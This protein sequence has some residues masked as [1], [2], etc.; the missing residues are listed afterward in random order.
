M[1]G[2]IIYSFGKRHKVVF[3]GRT[4][5]GC[6]VQGTVPCDERG[7][8]LPVERQ[9][10]VDDPQQSGSVIQR[11]PGVRETS[12]EAHAKGK[13]NGTFSKQQQLILDKI[14]S[15]RKSDHTRQELK[16][17]TGLEINAVCGRVN[18]LL[19]D[20]IGALEETRKRKCLVTGETAMAFRRK[21]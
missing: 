4:H 19:S 3:E 2:E 5:E 9:A 17:I 14:D 11:D 16:M 1:I 13:W 12:R 8:A 7:N 18:E 10:K 21:R 6:I 20:E 15:S